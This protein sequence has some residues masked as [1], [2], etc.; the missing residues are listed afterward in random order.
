MDPIGK[1]KVDFDCIYTPKEK[2]KL[3]PTKACMTM[4]AIDNKDASSVTELLLGDFGRVMESVPVTAYSFCDAVLFQISHDRNKYKAIDLMQQMA[5]YMAKNP[6][7]FVDIVKPFQGEYSYESYIKNMYHGTKYIDTEV[8]TAVLAL[9]WNLSI[10]I[11][12]PS[13]GTVPFYH[14]DTVADVVIV[15]NEKL[16]PDHYFCAT[17]PDNE[18]W[19]PIRGK[20][21]SNQITVLTNVKNAHAQAEK[22]LRTRLVNKVVGEF[23]TVTNKLNEMKDTLNLYQ[24]Q[25]ASMEQKLKQ[26]SSNVNLMEGKQGVLRLRLLELGVDANALTKTGPAVEGVHYTQKL[27]TEATPTSTISVPPGGD[28]GVPVSVEGSDTTVHAEIHPTP[29]ATCST[30]TVSTTS[31]ALNVLSQAAIDSAVRSSTTATTSTTS[32]SGGMIVPLSA[33]QIGQLITPGGTP[34][35]G[36]Q[37]ILSVGGQNVLVSGSGPGTVGNVSVRYG[38][39]LKGVHKYFCSKCQRP[40]TQKESLTR[41]EQENCPMLQGGKKKY[42]C[43]QCHQKFSSKQYLREHMHEIHLKQF[44]YF[45]K[46]CGKGYYKHCGLNHHKKSCLAVLAPGFAASQP[47]VNPPVVNPPVVN[48]AVPSD[49]A[50]SME[51][52]STT[53]EDTGDP[54][55]GGGIEY[56]FSDPLNLPN[57]GD[58]EDNDDDDDD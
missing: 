23:N 15:C 33:A 55:I 32:T 44:L 28:M 47:V 25:M 9:M 11:I 4:Y 22:K 12:Y 24:D 41:H 56:K 26:W 50:T 8:V 37:Q 58:D 38:K 49:T 3:K 14:P 18:R 45:C 40:F 52:T 19:R 46:G 29:T 17:K 53:A 34:V 30:D 2:K 36:V 51:T 54:L 21:W 13:R 42:E 48:P 16:Q 31:V 7:K 6:D 39:I 57:F 20:D 1:N 27:T 10:S 43:E 5:Y 35:G